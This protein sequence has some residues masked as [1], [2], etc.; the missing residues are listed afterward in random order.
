MSWEHTVLLVDDV[1]M[2]RELG[3]LFLARTGRVLTA[4]SGEEAIKI[5]RRERPDVILLDLMMP[6]LEGDAVCRAIKSD[7]E[8]S[9]TPVIMLVGANEAS[10]WG[11][12]VRAG[13]DDVLSKPISR[14]SL[15]KTVR[16]YLTGGHPP[17][18][19]RININSN[20]KIQHGSR[21]VT[22]RLKNLSRGG[23]FIETDCEFLTKS[24]VKLQF[25]LPDN[26]T[27]FDPTAQVIWTQINKVKSRN[28][29]IGMRFVNI[30][31]DLV[32]NLEDYIYDR[33]PEPYP[34]T[35]EETV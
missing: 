11:R 10:E 14:V 18:Q 19:P 32:R 33:A 27:D 22:A 15:I 2:F 1:E 17:G 4:R 25:E 35:L 9:D 23:I 20:V 12:A 16:R 24:E 6:G 5:A 13:A 30:S 29:G 7:P 31:S 34:A 8:L 26:P 28:R 3:S 21:S